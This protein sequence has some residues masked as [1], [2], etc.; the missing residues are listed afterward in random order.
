MQ[1]LNSVSDTRT[2]PYPVQLVIQTKDHRPCRDV[3]PFPA[4]ICTPP[5]T[6]L[7]LSHGMLKMVR[8]ISK[9]V[10]SLHDQILLLF[11]TV[12]WLLLCRNGWLCIDFASVI[13]FN[14]NSLFVLFNFVVFPLSSKTWSSFNFSCIRSYAV[15]WKRTAFVVSH[16]ILDNH[17]GVTS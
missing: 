5:L 10:C 7:P 14:I 16:S 13:Q 8:V 2:L 15:F 11:R 17:T 12:G 9:T 1:S 4:S 6:R 3:W